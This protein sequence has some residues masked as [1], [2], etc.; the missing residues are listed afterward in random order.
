MNPIRISNFLTN[1]SETTD[2]IS[3]YSD[4]EW[5]TLMIAVF[6]FLVSSLGWEA[7]FAANT[8]EKHTKPQVFGPFYPKKIDVDLS[9]HPPP[10]QWKKGDPIKDIPRKHYRLPDG[11]IPEPTSQI[12]PLLE[13]QRQAFSSTPQRTF[14]TLEIEIPGQGFSGVNPPDTVGDVGKDFYIQSINGASGTTYMIYDKEDG[15]VAAGPFTIQSLAMGGSCTGGMGDPIVMYD[16]LA[17]RWLLSEFANEGNWLCVYISQTSDPVSGGWY[18]YAFETPYFPDYPKYSVWPDAYYVGTNESTPALYALDRVAMLNGQPATMQRFTVSPLSGFGFQMLVPADIDGNTPPPANNPGYFMRHRDDEVHNVGSNNSA[19]DYLELFSFHVDWD[20]PANSTVSGPTSIPI[21]EIDS[22]LCGLT[23]F[24]CF[25]QP[26]GGAPLDPLREVVMWRLQY[27]NFND[28]AVLVSNLVTDVDSTDHGGIRWFELRKNGTDPWSLFQEGTYAPDGKNRWMGSIAMDGSGNM[29]LGYNVVDSATYPE[30]RYTGRLSLDPMGSMPQGEF[31]VVTGSASNASNRWGDYGAVNVDPEDDCTFWFTGM[32]NENTTWSTKICRFSFDACGCPDFMAPSDFTVANDGDNR[33]T[34]TWTSVPDA[35]HYRIYRSY[36]SCPQTYTLLTDNVTTTHYTDTT[37]SGGITYS[38]TVTA[39]N[40][41]SCESPK[42]GCDDAT[43]TG[44]CL[45]PPT[46]SGLESITNGQSATCSLHL[47]WSPST[48]VCGSSVVYNIYRSQTSGF[49][50]GSA[51]RIARCIATTSYTDTDVQSKT[52]YHYIVRAEDST[53][54]GSGPCTGGNEDSN[55]VEKSGT[56]TGGTSALFSDDIE[57]VNG[58]WQA[59]AGP[60]DGGGTSA[61]DISSDNSH[62]GNDAW[63]CT[64]EGMI[65][66]QLLEMVTATPIPLNSTGTRLTF[67]HYVDTETTYDGGVLEYSTD[68]GNHWHD[69]LE[70]NGAGVPGDADRI[71][72]N[73]YNSTISN[74]YG[75]PIG[76]RQAWSGN[77]SPYTQVAVDLADFSGQDVLFRWRL[78]CDASVGQNGWW[79]DD[80]VISTLLNCEKVPVSL[81]PILNYLLSE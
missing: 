57:T 77:I 40:A 15:S 14:D 35:H 62:S 33:L 65:K 79:I 30:L 27:R 41:D 51:N 64:D 34:L 59:V 48:P 70:G 13:Q 10:P 80:V 12:D 55:T 43:A 7:V 29:A 60:G 26:G 63:T 44:N 19:E 74:G 56:P 37:V 36:G 54:Y 5:V 4:M 2:P 49:T 61:W 20:T 75:S 16:P 47:S 22:T 18:Q 76:G 23:S 58:N 71:T 9:I 38:Y 32:Y 8:P 52:A 1:A 66:D 50:P 67:W 42:S 73:G 69:I 46:F 78:A 24:S 3:A 81:S 68:N 11:S 28:H 21:A 25:S 17:N 39:V 72:S 6:L 45:I 53:S 31:T